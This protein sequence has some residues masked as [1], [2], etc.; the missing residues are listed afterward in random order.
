MLKPVEMEKVKVL[1]LDE[2]LEGAVRE[3]G[4]FGAV[5]MKG[6]RTTH[7]SE[8]EELKEISLLEKRVRHLLDILEVT[9]RKDLFGATIPPEKMPLKKE[10]TKKQLEGVENFLEK[11]EESATKTSEEIKELKEEKSSLLDRKNNLFQ[12]KES[13]EILSELGGKTEW[14]DDSKFL[15]LA[16]GSLPKE[17]SETLLFLKEGLKK[18][19]CVWKGEE[20]EERVPILILTLQ[21]Y[22]ENLEQILG[23]LKWENYDLPPSGTENELKE[24]QTRI[25]E[26]NGK[27]GEL[28]GELEEIKEEYGEKLLAMKEI[29]ENEKSISELKLKFFKTENVHLLEGWIPR[30]KVRELKDRL[31]KITKKHLFLKS[32]PAGEERVPTHL[33]NPSIVKPFESLTSTFGLPG[34]NEVDPTILLAIT[35]PLFFGLMFGDV[36]HGALVA[37]LGGAISHFGR[38]DAGVKNLGKVVVACGIF[39]MIFGFLYGDIFGLGPYDPHHPEAISQKTIFGFTMIEKQWVSPLHEPIDFLMIAIYIAI[40]Q[41]SMGLFIDLKNKISQRKFLD[42]F[43]SPVI[44]L[45]LYFGTIFFLMTYQLDFGL[46]AENILVT[47]PLILI[48]LILIFFSELIKHIKK[49]N[50]KQ[51]PGL[52]GEGGFEVFDTL[53]IFMSNTISYSRLFALA[54]V[55]AGLFLALFTISEMFTGI[56]VVGKLVWFLVIVVG[57]ILILALEAII[58]FLHSLRLHYYEWFTKFFEADGIPFKP[59]KIKRVYTYIKE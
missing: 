26:I 8:S 51:I 1:V 49:L 40:F 27:T 53:L 57:T 37:L 45:W 55:H 4:E 12:Y 50:K 13:L 41:I 5:E 42:A 30:K 59:F 58:V 20:R 18:D 52:L 32:Y 28:Q 11:I 16:F 6:L 54:L 34:Y 25:K 10:N 15:Y 3:C 7:S 14:L 36:G 48:P 17:D 21:E 23:G 35:F 24:I 19:F 56:P 38:R 47:I 43:T 46:W 33:E 39:S 2:Y 31:E 44:K 9:E 22:K 29:V